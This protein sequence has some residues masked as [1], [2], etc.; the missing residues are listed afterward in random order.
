MGMGRGRNVC[1][2]NT[3]PRISGRLWNLDGSDTKRFRERG[4]SSVPVFDQGKILEVSVRSGERIVGADFSTENQAALWTE[5]GNIYKLNFGQNGYWKVGK[6]GVVTHARFMGTPPHHLIAGLNTGRAVMIDTVTGA[7]RCRF[8]ENYDIRRVGCSH[9]GLVVFTMCIDH[10]TMWDISTKQAKFRLGIHSGDNLEFVNIFQMNPGEA[11]RVA[12][13]TKQGKLGVWCMKSDYFTRTKLLGSRSAGNMS[14]CKKLD[15]RYEVSIGDTCVGFSVVSH[16][17]FVT[18]Q[19]RVV[20]INISNGMT[21]K[22]CNIPDR[23]EVLNLDVKVFEDQTIVVLHFTAESL[24]LKNGEIINAIYCV[25]SG[26]FSQDGFI[27]GKLKPNGIVEFYRTDESWSKTVR[28][29]SDKPLKK[30][31]SVDIAIGDTAVSTADKAT[32][33]GNKTT[34]SS[35]AAGGKKVKHG[36]GKEEGITKSDQAKAG[37]DHE[38]L[39]SQITSPLLLP[40]LR[41][42]FLSYPAI[43]RPTIWTLLLH[44]PRNKRM[45]LKFCKVNETSPDKITHNLILWSPHLKLI[46]HLNHF[47][48]PFLKIFS[49]HPTTSFEFCMTILGKYSWLSSYPSPPPVFVMAWSL[50]SVECAELTNH[51]ASISVNSRTLFWPLLQTGWSSV[52]PYS[53]WL[54]LWDHF[55][56]AGPELTITALPATILCLQATLLACTTSTM[57]GNLISNQPAL[58]IKELLSTAYNLMDKHQSKV[59]STQ[60][61]TPNTGITESGYPTPIRLEKEGWDVLKDLNNSNSKQ[62]VD[63]LFEVTK[64]SNHCKKVV[65]QAL[66][67]SPP[68]IPRARSNQ[69]DDLN[70]ENLGAESSFQPVAVTT[71]NPIAPL[72]PAYPS[73]QVLPPLSHGEVNA[74]G[75]M[76]DITAL[77]QKAKLLRQVIQTKI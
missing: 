77:L 34:V 27:L 31:R 53:D 61:E 10:V 22:V 18:T 36:V 49:G 42:G 43:P 46:P 58:N 55:I 26:F 45:Y 60:E 28:S 21:D 66:R 47:I 5:K 50:L 24:F 19:S 40:L 73:T 30:V 69:R 54:R 15:M 35:R 33:T 57:V 72:E 6:P 68:P 8:V 37:R 44:L 59:R 25:G 29:N 70:K 12:S 75:E 56:T 3:S 76:E 17:L 11:Y 9:D 63:T 48:S 4:V 14:K 51:L 23:G 64:K 16:N 67:V 38:L 32:A 7:I 74:I 13:V 39:L 65:K 2:L 52:L 41:S 1:V 71:I 20:K 62:S